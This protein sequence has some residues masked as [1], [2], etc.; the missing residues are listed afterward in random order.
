MRTEIGHTF[1]GLAKGINKQDAIHI[2]VLL[3]KATFTVKPGDKV[4]VKREGDWWVTTNDETV[5]P[6]GVADPFIERSI[7]EGCTF[8]VFVYPNTVMNMT[9]SW[10]HPLLGSKDEAKARFEKHAEA[11]G[12]S[13]EDLLSAAHRANDY[14]EYHTQYGTDDQRDYMLSLDLKEFWFDFA[15]LTGAEIHDDE[16]YVYSCTC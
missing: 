11:L 3:V 15:T 9:H 10:T 2:A 1:G 4:R 14:G 8:Y 16:H 6:L 5:E 7:E 13:Y 12:V